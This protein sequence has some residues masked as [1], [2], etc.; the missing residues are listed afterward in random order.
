MGLQH[1]QGQVGRATMNDDGAC[2]ELGSR[3]RREAVLE[4]SVPGY[5]DG[6]FT[7]TLGVRPMPPWLP[8]RPSFSRLGRLEPETA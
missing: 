8:A 1:L 3:Y 5:G 2:G 4:P 7:D 6:V